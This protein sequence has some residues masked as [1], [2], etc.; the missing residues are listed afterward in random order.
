MNSGNLHGL[1]VFLKATATRN[2]NTN[3]DP[4]DY[5][6]HS[7]QVPADQCDGIYAAPYT[8][9]GY[10]NPDFPKKG[11][12][13]GDTRCSWCV[14]NWFDR[15]LQSWEEG[16]VIDPVNGTHVGLQEY[17][18]AIEH[19]GR[20]CQPSDWGRIWRK[21]VEMYKERGLLPGDWE[22]EKGVYVASTYNE[23]RRLG[24]GRA[25]PAPYG[26][27]WTEQSVYDDEL[28]YDQTWD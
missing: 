13:D 15:K 12:N 26:R 8:S 22:G 24:L 16:R 25:N 14:M 19:A 4:D 7:Y 1:D 28:F 17:L 18:R 11:P 10:D 21:N 3:E 27:G 9:R 20:R 2:T 5:Y 23:D 6:W